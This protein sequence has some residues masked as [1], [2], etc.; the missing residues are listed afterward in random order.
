[1]VGSSGRGSLLEGRK[2]SAGGKVGLEVGFGLSLELGESVLAILVD[3]VCDFE[4]AAR[5]GVGLFR[6]A[7]LCESASEQL[8]EGD[9]IRHGLGPYEVAEAE[10]AFS[11]DGDGFGE[12]FVARDHEEPVGLGHGGAVGVGDD[13]DEDV[14]HDNDEHEGGEVED[15]EAGGALVTAQV[16]IARHAGDC[17]RLYRL[18]ERVEKWTRRFRRWSRTGR[19]RGRRGGDRGCDWGA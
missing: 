11:A 13:G 9:A 6:V 19:N 10:G 15:D 4:D 3:A 16:E 5:G 7:V 8:V 1:M 2:V 14:E 12:Y 17:G 18:A